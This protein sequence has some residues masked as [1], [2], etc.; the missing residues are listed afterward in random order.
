[1]SVFHRSSFVRTFG[2]LC[3]GA[4]L[5]L[6]AASVG[7]AADV[8]ISGGAVW[9]G[10]VGAQVRLVY[11]LAGKEVT[12]EGSVS[13]IDTALKVV[14]IKVSEG[15]KAVEKTIFWSDIRKMESIS[16]DGK[17]AAAGASG[18]KPG[19]TGV[20][21]SA[22]AGVSKSSASSSSLGSR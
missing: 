5:A 11:A 8:K 7:F 3:L 2:A 17:S 6:S 10:D 21:W 15:G 1:M 22:Q 14:K 16:G 20:K 13:K 12:I 18:A 19:A 4:A 9:K